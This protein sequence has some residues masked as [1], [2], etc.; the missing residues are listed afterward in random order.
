M[1]QTSDVPQR[2][3]QA[4][5]KL[6]F[7][8]GYAKTQLRLIASKAG[9][10]E[11][12]VL[13]IFESKMFLLRAVCDSCWAEINA[14]VERAVAEASE[15]D[16]DP[17]NLLLEIMRTVLQFAQTNKPMMTFLYTHFASPEAI[18]YVPQSAGFDAPSLSSVGREFQQYYGRLE[19]LCIEVVE[20]NPGFGAAGVTPQA[21]QV[22]VQA[23]IYGVQASWY[24]VDQSQ[25][26]DSH[27]ISIEEMAA[28]LRIFLYQN[29]TLESYGGLNGF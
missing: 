27:R 7:A 13:R 15:R 25:M 2:I 8:N 11:S 4:A 3:L 1:G 12:G 21:M 16:S 19:K 23:G 26:P 22:F 28:C 6:F 9:T 14:E 17:R 24:I 18:G 29:A 10:S 20:N 5:R